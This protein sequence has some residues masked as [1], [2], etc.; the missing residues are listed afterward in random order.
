MPRYGWVTRCSARSGTPSQRR[1]RV[2]RRQRRSIAR[3]SLR[4]VFSALRFRED[5]LLVDVA[6][7]RGNR[8]LDRHFLH[9][10]AQAPHFLRRDRKAL[11]LA[12]AVDDELRA[13]PMGLR[14]DGLRAAASHRLVLAL[15]AVQ[16]EGRALRL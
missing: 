5:L 12:R 14:H 11:N 10:G 16:L 4:Y 7:R 1:T 3:T 9:V 8:G 15:G 6:L 13:V 2:A